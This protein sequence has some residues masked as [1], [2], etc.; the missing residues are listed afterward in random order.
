MKIRIDKATYSYFEEYHLNN[1]TCGVEVDIPEDLYD[2][3]YKAMNDY[4]EAQEILQKLYKEAEN[5]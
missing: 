2:K 5:K 4:G 3:I 1:S